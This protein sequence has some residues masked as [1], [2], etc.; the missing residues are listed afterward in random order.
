VNPP[1]PDSQDTTCAPAPAAAGSPT[2]RP[3]LLAGG[4][5]HLLHPASRTSTPA[6]AGQ[7]PRRDGHRPPSRRHRHHRL[8]DRARPA[9][10]P[11]SNP[12]IHGGSSA[13]T[14]GTA[15]NGKECQPV[16][17]DMTAACEIRAMPTASAGLPVLNVQVNGAT[18]RLAGLLCKTVG[19]A[20]VG[21]NPTP[22]TTSTAASKRHVRAPA[23]PTGRGLVVSGHVRPPSATYGRPCPIRAQVGATSLRPRGG[24]WRGVNARCRSG[25]QRSSPRPR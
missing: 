3:R 8:D 5:H 23:R 22:A 24:R 2:S 7:E 4:P 18:A 20:Y 10:R 21:S 1:C 11:D 19:S 14:T 13:N 25:A 15:I 9:R 12:A 17:H 6:H 16:G